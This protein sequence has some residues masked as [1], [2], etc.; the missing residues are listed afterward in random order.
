MGIKTLGLSDSSQTKKIKEHCLIKWIEIQNLSDDLF[1][2]KLE[3]WKG[4]APKIWK[5]FLRRD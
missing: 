2:E 5:K 1:I 3:N 4:S